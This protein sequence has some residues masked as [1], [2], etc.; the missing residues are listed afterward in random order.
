MKHSSNYYQIANKIHS[1]TIWSWQKTWGNGL[2]RTCTTLVLPV[3]ASIGWDIPRQ[4]KVKIAEAITSAFTGN[5]P[6]SFRQ[7][8]NVR[9]LD[10]RTCVKRSKSCSTLS[11]DTA[12]FWQGKAPLSW[13]G[14]WWMLWCWSHLHLSSNFTWLMANVYLT[15]VQH[16]KDLENPHTHTDCIY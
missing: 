3:S 7:N 6:E 13:G 12:V 5:C 16:W 14:A 15:F 8:M 1:L 10:A 2:P 11:K 9:C 4:V